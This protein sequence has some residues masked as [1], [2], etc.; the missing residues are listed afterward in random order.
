MQ[1]FQ[2]EIAFNAIKNQILW[3]IVCVSLGDNLCSWKTHKLSIKRIIKIA[4]SDAIGGT[5]YMLTSIPINDH[6][7]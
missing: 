6:G 4:I 3:K 1:F 2:M 5:F 7:R